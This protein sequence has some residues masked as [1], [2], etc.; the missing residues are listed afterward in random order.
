VPDDFGLFLY[1]E[2]PTSFP[3]GNG[4]LCIGSPFFRL[5]ASLAQGGELRHAL[6]MTNPP[7]QVAIITP[8]STWNFQA[9][10]RDNPAGGSGFDLTDGLRVT[11]V[12]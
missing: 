5:P 2:F 10:F 3:L 8:G 4:T 11:F 7:A 6:D 12:P 9:W 1:G